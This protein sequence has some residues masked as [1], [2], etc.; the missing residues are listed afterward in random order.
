ML[1]TPDEVAELSRL[2]DDALA[3]ESSERESWLVQQERDRPE[4]ARRLRAIL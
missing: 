3:L 4:M 2:L 1:M